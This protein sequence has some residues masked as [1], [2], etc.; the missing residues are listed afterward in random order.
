MACEVNWPESDFVNICV[1]HVPV[2][3]WYICLQRGP[4]LSSAG[5]TAP[6]SPPPSSQARQCH[7]SE[8]LSLLKLVWIIDIG[9]E[10]FTKEV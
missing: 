3:L 9:M 1:M 2:S 5:T 4:G 10:N 8:L 6:H 7:T